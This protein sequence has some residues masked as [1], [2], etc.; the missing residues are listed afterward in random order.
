MSHVLLRNVV[1]L[2]VIT[3][4]P[5]AAWADAAGEKIGTLLRDYGSISRDLRQ[6]QLAQAE[7]IKQKAALDIR[8]SDLSTRQGALN[9]HPRDPNAAADNQQQ[10]P[11]ENKNPCNNQDHV[12]G[13]G[14][15]QHL[16]DCDNKTK[17]LKKMGIAGNAGVLPLETRQTELDLEFNLY[18][19]AADD[20]NAQEQ[21]T[22]TALNSLYRALNS[23]ADRADDFI[24]SAPFQEEIEASH[25]HQACSQRALPDGMLSIDELQ[26]YTVGAERCLNYVAAQRKPA[27]AG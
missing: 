18:N 10:A 8:G 24:G 14:T 6:T 3:V 7:L 4:T 1:L 17:K 21:Q 26:D 25:A 11:G 23:W 16:N 2:A 27:P 19:Q 15:P 13:K 12:N 22:I 5:T 9:A 20:W